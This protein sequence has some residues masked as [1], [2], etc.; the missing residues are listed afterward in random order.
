MVSEPGNGIVLLV[1]FFIAGQKQLKENKS[2]F[3]SIVWSDVV[4][5]G[6]GGREHLTVS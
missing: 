3:R 2:L 1:P 5:H 6:G 4:H